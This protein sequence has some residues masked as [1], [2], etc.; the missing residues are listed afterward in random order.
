MVRLAVIFSLACQTLSFAR[1]FKVM[2]F[3]L[4]SVHNPSPSRRRGLPYPS[5]FLFGTQSFVSFLSSGPSA[6]NVLLR[7]RCCFGNTF[8]SPLAPRRSIRKAFCRWYS[9]WKL[10]PFRVSSSRVLQS[11][12][13]L[14]CDERPDLSLLC[15]FL[16]RR[17]LF[18]F[19][20]LLFNAFQCL[21]VRSLSL[22]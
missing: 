13:L 8:N 16:D 20:L 2:L 21:A 17:N 10:E 7:S 4:R 22:R 15:C 9:V 12:F 18:P 1:G 19:T 6:L 3:L 14:R 11:F 5:F